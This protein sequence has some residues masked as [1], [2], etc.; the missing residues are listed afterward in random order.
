MEELPIIFVLLPT[1]G[2]D[3]RGVSTDVTLS[4]SNPEQCVSVEVV[5]DSAVEETESL[6]VS[7]SLPA[8][9][10]SSLQLTPNTATILITDNDGKC[11]KEI[12]CSLL[13]SLIYRKN[14]YMFSLSPSLPLSLSPSL[15]PSLSPSLSLSLP[16][17]LSPSPSPS[18]PPSLSIPP[19]ISVVV[20]GFVQSEY[21]A[22]E[23]NM[24]VIVCV[25]VRQGQ[26]GT[27]VS[28]SLTTL[29]RT[30]HG[31]F[32]NCVHKILCMCTCINTLHMCTVV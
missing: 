14:V 11:F 6:T 25:E 15:P 28:L 7:L 23:L 24:S 18:L 17:S 19:P 4:P 30:A 13:I 3:Y 32:C 16:L 9:G 21:V 29:S 5:D 22:S 26:L 10:L 1:E 8:G 12:N 20:V 31:T 2:V 27:P